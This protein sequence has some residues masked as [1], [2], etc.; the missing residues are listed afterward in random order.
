MLRLAFW[1]LVLCVVACTVPS[2]P[3]SKQFPRPQEP[4]DPR[5]HKIADVPSG[6]NSYNLYCVS[7]SVCW[8]GDSSRQWRTDDA[9]Q[10]W[11]LIYSSAS[12]RS[13]I[14]TVDYVDA[15]VA[16]ILTLQKLLKT[17]DG[18]RTWVEQPEPLPD[19]PLGELRTIS[20]LRGGRIGWAGGGIYRPLTTDEERNGVPRNISDP[21][22]HT[23]LKLA[24]Y[25]TEDG[26]KTWIPQ[27][28]PNNAGRVSGFTFLNERQGLAFESSELFYTTNGGKQWK[29]VDLKKS[30]TD[31][32]YLEGYDMRPVEVS[33]LDSQNAWLLF[34]DGRITRS[35]D[36]AR[37]W[38]D[39]L[40]PRMVNFDSDRKYFK[41]IHFTDLSHGWALGANGSLYETKDG[42]KTWTKS[43]NSEFD[44]M[45]FFDVQT[46]WLVSKAGLFQL[47]F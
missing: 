33:F 3:S 36:G 15:Q 41:Q 27:S 25:H 29:Y 47:S 30:C 14:S 9:G 21:P 35:T 31:Q 45:F 18:G 43:V 4:V 11:H 39:L 12:D 1:C 24:I 46:G 44:D 22:S 7:T 19:Y 28:I 38:C 6:P 17:E 32:R 2:H 8:V 5:L 37:T 20:F 16:W 10:H 42:G 34:E 26:G 23:I 40:A 13:Q